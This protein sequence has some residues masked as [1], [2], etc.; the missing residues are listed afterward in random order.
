MK[1]IISLFERDYEGNRQ[2]YDK[3]VEGAEWV[4]AGEGWATRK[5]DGTACMINAGR[6]YARYDVKK[7]RTPPDGFIPAQEADAT[8]G[9]WPGWVEVL[10]QPQYKWHK[11]AFNDVVASGC[12]LAEGTYELCGPHF[13]TNPE[14]LDKDTLIPHGKHPVNAPRSFAELKEWFKDAGI[15]GVVWH[16]ANGDMVKIKA[17]DFGIKRSEH[18]T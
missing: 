6:L 13:Q 9:H 3:V 14:S 2:V 4:V 1:K 10:D 12:M 11:A 15:E 16:R 5:W 7:G 18:L 8:T 17:R